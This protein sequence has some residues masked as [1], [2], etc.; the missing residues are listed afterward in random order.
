MAHASGNDLTRKLGLELGGMVIVY[1]GQCVFCSAYIRMLRLRAAAG[2][3]HMLDARGNDRAL[4]IKSAT[5]LDLNTG[6][7]V[8]HGDRI[9]AGADAIHFIS[10]LSS[11]SGLV[12]RMLGR[13]FTS[14][15]AAQT[16]YPAL[17]FG[18]NITLRLLGRS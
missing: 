16:L 2:P 8:I 14:E 12:N 4:V 6:M 5:G 10:L 13:V 15:R 9:Y 3:V 11:S 18:R 17:R 1:D 7:L